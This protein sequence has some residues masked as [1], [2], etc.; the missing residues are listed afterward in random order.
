MVAVQ[1]FWV[2]GLPRPS[3][4]EFCLVVLTRT[5]TKKP[6]PNAKRELLWR[7]QVSFYLF[8]FI[9]EVGGPTGLGFRVLHPF[10]PCGESSAVVEK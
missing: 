1:L 5:L 10:S 3:N 7:D 6:L 9:L 2:Q 4:V 8:S